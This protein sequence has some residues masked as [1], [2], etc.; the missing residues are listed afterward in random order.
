MLDGVAA[1]APPELGECLSLTAEPTAATGG[2]VPLLVYLPRP[3]APAAPRVLPTT[4]RL[5]QLFLAYDSAPEVRPLQ[6]LQP[7]FIRLNLAAKNQGRRPSCA[8]YAIVSALEF[9]NAQLTGGLEKL[10]EEYLIWATRRSLGQTAAA[11]VP[12]DEAGE[13]LADAGYTLPSVIAALQT[14]GIPRYEDMP[15][16]P[17]LAPDAV[18]A[19]DRALIER[20]RARRLVFIAA[21]PG[22]D[23][24]AR[25]NALVHALNAGFPVPAGLRWPHENS[26]HAG[27]LAAQRPLAGAAHAVTF[28]GYSC[29]TGRLEEASFIFKNSYGPRWG[30]GGYGRAGW[31][32]LSR[33]LLEAY[34]LDVRAPDPSR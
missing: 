30:Q 15:N 13:P 11:A 17:G 7:E 21:L 3:V 1:W 5:D 27:V 16:Q 20:A 22:A 24:R 34:V 12:R 9:Q 25:V 23:A 18:P 33:H 2:G 31:D 8:I 14:Y 26:I 6:S 19:P 29:P 10:S 32:Y 28:I 4:S